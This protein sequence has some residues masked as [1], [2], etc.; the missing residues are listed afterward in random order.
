VDYTEDKR[1]NQGIFGQYQGTFGAF[2]LTVGLRYDDNDAYGDHGTGNLALGYALDPRLKAILSYGTAFKAP[3]FNDL[4]YPGF[5]NPQLLPEESKSWELGLTGEPAWGNWELRLFVTEVDNLIQYNPNAGRPENIASAR[6]EGLESRITTRLA[7]WDLAAS[8]TLLDPRDEESGELLQRRARK[9]LR[10]DA[11]RRF[12]K[13]AFGLTL[14]A[15]D[16]REDLDYTIWPATP[17]ALSGYGLVDLRLSRQLGRDWLLRGQI[18]NLFDK[19][20]ETVYRYNSLGRELF[21]TLS[22]A[23]QSL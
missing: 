20:H 18:K 22:Y 11:D 23:P 16:S 8:L 4:Y 21:I 6:I 7:D 19:T 10:L 14:L 1:D 3:S 13:S 12:G 5:S 15:Q 2:E 17:V 9:T